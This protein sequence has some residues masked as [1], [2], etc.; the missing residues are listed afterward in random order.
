M[1]RIERMTAILLVLQDKGHP[2]RTSEEIAATFEVSRRTVIRDIQALCEMGV[3]VIAQEGSGGG[4][5]LPEDYTL[6]PLPLTT[7][8]AILMLLSLSTL[9]K[10]ADL[11]FAPE[12]ASLFAKLRSLLTDR[13]NHEVEKWMGALSMEVPERQ[14]DT[15]FLEQLLTCAKEGRWV[16]ASYQSSR[17]VSSGLLLPK[18]LTSSNGFWYCEAYALEHQEERRY[19][20][21]RFLSVEPAE[22]PAL[23]TPM[24]ATLPYNHESH[25]EVRIFL[26][27]T[28]VSKVE[29][30]PH[31]GNDIQLQEDGSGVCLFR[32]PPSELNWLARYLLDL[33]TQAK[34]LAPEELKSKLVE[35]AKGILA[36]YQ[37]Q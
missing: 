34:V 25:P 35:L 12:R 7:N 16:Q 18:R 17:R 14:Y 32:C 2:R 27:P 30:E 26:T 36:Q 20:A 3:P 37:D 22:A 23:P 13:Q 4:Y 28:G 9:N 11:P 24:A 29:Q 21:D 5:S 1:N 19:R 6:P 8:E 33:G 15:P 31:L 10:L